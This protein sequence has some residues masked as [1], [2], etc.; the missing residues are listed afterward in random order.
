MDALLDPENQRIQ[1]VFCMVL[2]RS[3]TV[4]GKRASKRYID[5]PIV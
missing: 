5:F 1:A 3:V 2:S 4:G